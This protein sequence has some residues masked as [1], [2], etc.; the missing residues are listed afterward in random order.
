M[1]HKLLTVTF[2]YTLIHQQLPHPVNEYCKFF[3]HNYSTRQRDNKTLVLPK[4][5][6]EHGKRSITFC[7]SELWNALPDDIKI[8]PSVTSFRNAVKKK[9]LQ[10]YD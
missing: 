8:K 7:G 10:E 1:I 3:K 6:T 9:L 5:K 4:V 2:M